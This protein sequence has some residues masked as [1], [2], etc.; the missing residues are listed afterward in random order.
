MREHFKKQFEQNTTVTQEKLDK[1]TQK[2]YTS[3]REI[4]PGDII[5]FAILQEEGKNDDF[6]CLHEEE[7]NEYEYMGEGKDIAPKI[8]KKQVI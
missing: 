6:I 7:L 3:G 4:K 2:T 1:V 8:R 5:L